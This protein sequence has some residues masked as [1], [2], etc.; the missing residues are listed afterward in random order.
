[1]GFLVLLYPR[2]ASSHPYL[3]GWLHV[4]GCWVTT[5]WSGEVLLSVFV[6]SSFGK[7]PQGPLLCMSITY[8]LLTG[9]MGQYLLV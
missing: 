9:H 2:T 7:Y 1:M 5:P 8:G 4:L 3:R 6:S